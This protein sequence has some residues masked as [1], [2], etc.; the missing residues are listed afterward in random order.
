M[1]DHSI[2]WSLEGSL[3]LE[4]CWE[5]FLKNGEGL[6]FWSYEYTNK[7]ISRLEEIK[8]ASFLEEILIKLFGIDIDFVALKELASNKISRRENFERNY[9]HWLF[10][11]EVLVRVDGKTRKLFDWAKK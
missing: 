2:S 6:A 4:I 3:W 11:I 1:V 9:D 5:N 10:N 7:N 8:F